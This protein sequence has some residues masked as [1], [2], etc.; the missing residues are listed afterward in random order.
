MATT[1]IGDCPAWERTWREAIRLEAE[2]IVSEEAEAAAQRVRDRTRDLG[3]RLALKLSRMAEVRTMS[4]RIVIELH[5]DVPEPHV[6]EGGARQT[7]R[8]DRQPW[9]G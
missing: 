8:G 3:A 2:R 9:K 7:P 6:S 5:L 1:V 4:D